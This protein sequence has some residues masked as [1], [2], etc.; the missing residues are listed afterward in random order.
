[1][2]DLYSDLAGLERGYNDIP[3]HEEYVPSGKKRAADTDT[4]YVPTQKR[5]RTSTPISD[6]PDS[7]DVS[8]SDLDP[9]NSEKPSPPEKKTPVKAAVPVTTEEDQRIIIEKELNFSISSSSSD[10]DSSDSDVE[11]CVSVLR[12]LL[13]PGQPHCR[14]LKMYGDSYCRGGPECGYIYK[15]NY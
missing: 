1:M 13:I 6:I 14:G 11:P 4:V 5:P 8:I 9:E 2:R 12:K 15:D 10:S 7:P 3:S